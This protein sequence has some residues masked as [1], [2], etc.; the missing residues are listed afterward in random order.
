MAL[1]DYALRRDEILDRITSV[2]EADDRIRAAWLSGSF[3]RRENDE[4]SDLDL[5]MAVADDCLQAILS[6]RTDLY[7]LAGVPLLIQEDME[8][9]SQPG[10]RFQLVMYPGPVEVD[11]NIGPESQAVR[12]LNFKMLIERASLPV[13]RAAPLTLDN[14]RDR[15]QHW[16]TFFWAMAPIGI[17]LCG[18]RDTRRA[19]KQ[20][21]LQTTAYIALWRLT[22]NPGSGMVPNAANPIFE[23]ELQA[24]I[25]LVSPT[26]T[27][28]TVL[29]AMAALADRVRE[30]HPTLGRL[31]V[32]VPEDIARQ[33]G[34]FNDLAAQVL[35][36]DGDGPVRYR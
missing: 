36:E 14:R 29:A 1:R 8:S 7:L 32:S 15:A 31:G 19:V 12:P 2:L 13:F 18:R 3:G 27:P 35:S 16:A 24:A 34:E 25:P 17:K 28:E 33:I 21:D 9:D 11:W 23:P 10:A 26:I 5:H 20:L 6:E 30:L 22:F 4:W